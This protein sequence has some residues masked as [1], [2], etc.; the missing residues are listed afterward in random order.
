[1]ATK[2]NA[3]RTVAWS[4]AIDTA[5]LI[6]IWHDGSPTED[7]TAVTAATIAVQDGTTP[8]DITLTINGAVDSRIGASGVMN[9]LGASYN[10]AGEVYDHVNSVQGW[11]CRIEGMLRAGVL[12]D[13][14]RGCVIAQSATTCF[15]TPV[16]I[17]RDTTITSKS[18]GW[19]HGG[20]I[21]Q[22]AAPTWGTASKGKIRA[23]ESEHGFRNQLDYLSFT[24]TY[25]SGTS[26]INVYETDGVTET[27]VHTQ[28]GGATTVAGTYTPTK[29]IIAAPGYRLMVQLVNS[30]AM[31]AIAC[32]V[33]GRS[34]QA[35]ASVQVNT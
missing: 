30:A 31:T 17:L 16:T 21:S 18:A 29:P 28:A 6:T 13:G 9:L 33:K 25:A 19:E 4:Y 8:V 32:D 12:S 23:I 24:S 10:T 15:K 22:R 27:L 34:W 35:G 26:T 1:M 20:V 3:I 11:N 5:P 7:G 2:S 14:T